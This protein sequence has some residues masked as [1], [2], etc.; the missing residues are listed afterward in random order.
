MSPTMSFLAV[1]VV[2]LQCIAFAVANPRA[3][4]MEFKKLKY[5][6][7]IDRRDGSLLLTLNNEKSLYT[8]E[9]DI[10]TPPQKFIVL[11]DTGSSDLFVPSIDEDYCQIQP[12]DCSFT[13]ACG[14]LSDSLHTDLYK[15]ERMN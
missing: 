2:I 15:D 11:I 8:V 10:G 1:A 7:T 9:L 6:N 12:E 13:G 3:V 14:Y 4:G 5:R